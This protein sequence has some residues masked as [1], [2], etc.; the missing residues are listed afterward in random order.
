MPPAP[1]LDVRSLLV[2]GGARSG[3]SRYA[4]QVAEQAQRTP[5]YLATAQVWDAEM[6]A[7]IGLHQAER[8][9]RW[10][11][12][13]EPIDLVTALQREARPDRI[14]LVDCL[15]LWLTNILLA[16]APV[17]EASEGLANAC[18]ALAGP[19]IFV[20]N[21]VGQGIVPDNALA[22]E[23][24]DA[25]GRLN[26][27]MAEACDAVIWVAAGLPQ[28]VKPMPSPRLNFNI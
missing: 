11:T 24:R 20:S 1:I 6:Q 10:T 23:F 18:R 8:D 15:T 16:G 25:Q 19:V 7:R 28:V 12:L 9:A 22:R 14:I 27:L 21:E 4:Q 5:I 13:E 2:L 26:Q 3:K 17:A